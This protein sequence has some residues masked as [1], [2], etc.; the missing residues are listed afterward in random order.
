[1]GGDRRG[2]LPGQP[3]SLLSTRGSEARKRED[4]PSETA[5]ANT[6]RSRADMANRLATPP[7]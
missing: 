4:T 1:M 7:H 2:R 5:A 6:S 3:A